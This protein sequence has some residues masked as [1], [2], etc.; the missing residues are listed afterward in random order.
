MLTRVL[1]ILV[2]ALLAIAAS[3]SPVSASNA[4]ISITASPDPVARWNYL[5]YRICVDNNGSTASLTIDDNLPTGLDQYNA[6]Y[7]IDQSEWQTLPPYG[8]ISLGKLTKGQ[9][10]VVEIKARVQA[11]A[12]ATLTNTVNLTDGSEKLDSETVEVNILPSVDAGPDVMIGLGETITF[13][14]AWAKDGQGQIA[15][16]SWKA[17]PSGIPAGTF[18]DPSVL[19]PTYTAPTVSGTVQMTLIATDSNGGQSS[20][21]FWLSVNSFPIVNAGAGK[22]VPETEQLLLEDS[23]AVDSDGYIVSYKWED[24]GSGGTFDDRKKLHAIYTAPDINNCEGK[25]VILTLT[26]TDNLG[27][28]STDQVRVHIENVN[29]LPKVDAGN[30]QNVEPGVQVTLSGKAVD[31]DGDI[32]CVIWEQIDGPLVTLS[33]ET[34]LQTTF[35]APSTEQTLQFRLT[36]TDTCKGTISDR[37]LVHVQPVYQP[38]TPSKKAAISISVQADPSP[39]SLRETIIYTYKVTNSGEVPLSSI[40]VIDT[41]LGRIGMGK[42]ALAPEET[43]R[44]ASQLVVNLDLFP[45]PLVSEASVTGK[46]DDNRQVTDNAISTVALRHRSAKIEIIFTALDGRGFPISPFDPVHVEDIISYHYKITNTGESRLH[47]L[48]LADDRSDIIPLPKDQIDPWETISG[49]FTAEITQQDLPGP[50][51]KTVTVCATDPHGQRLEAS[52][53]LVLYG[54]SHSTELRL[55]KSCDVEKAAIGQ[56]ITY[57]YSITNVGMTTIVELELVDDHL[58]KIVLPARVIAPGE[59]IF[60]YAEYEVSQNDLPGPLTNAASITGKDLGENKTSTSTSLSIEIAQSS[61]G[62]GGGS[63]ISSDGKII[64][65]EIAWAG[66]PASSA[67]EWIELRNLGQIPVDL[68]GWCIAWYPKE[69]TIPPEDSWTKVTL[70]GTISPYPLTNDDADDLGNRIA[71]IPSSSKQWR[72]M[73]TSWWMAGKRGKEGRGYY[74]L[75]RRN[76]NTVS[77]VIADLIYDK[78]TT[79]EYILPDTGAVILLIDDNGNVID[80]ANSEHPQIAGWPA[81]DVNTCA[82]MERTN[83]LRGDLDSNWHTNPGILING[84]DAA[85]SRLIAT[86]GGPNSPSLDQ[87]TLF[88]RDNVTPVEATGKVEVRIAGEERPRVRVTAVG[89][90]GSGV[91]ATASSGLSFSTHFSSKE[92][93][94]TIQTSALA[95]GEYFVWITNGAGESSLVLVAI[96]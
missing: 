23:S 65:S 8:M 3:V 51:E 76:Q 75:E 22:S 1:P 78:S 10:V 88:G 18:I 45:G 41:R 81:G 63:S 11:N 59:T 19:H 67:D 38:P 72:V 47:D 93:L 21:S 32:A 16:Y 96:T 64:I 42:T 13:S 44:G 12:P 7:N 80:T 83:P 37:T 87:L 55:K 9:T 91:A 68:T 77:D 71:F 36:A 33:D 28:A 2:G 43:T 31:E 54:L 90:S 50:F 46:T 35:T 15:S 73:D 4:S 56:I 53:K 6:S 40:E 24:N 69:G 25:D 60:G 62:A 30:D 79:Y 14:D 61:A 66:T 29:Q 92:S 49:Q 70:T 26:V 20:D 34:N 48:M 89:L 17:Q 5:T 27:A 82:T 94:L 39:A 86:A 85:G 57:E 58:G 52:D 84:H 74:L 95:P